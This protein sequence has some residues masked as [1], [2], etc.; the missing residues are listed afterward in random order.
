MFS[1]NQVKRIKALA[2]KK[3]RQESGQFVVEGHKLVTEL[4]Q[5]ELRVLEV[6][7]LPEWIENASLPLA[8]QPEVKV[9]PVKPN[10]MERLTLLNSPSPVL[11]IL[12]IPEPQK[13][14]INPRGLTLVL[15]R[16]NDPGNLGTLIRIADWFGVQQLVCSSDT[17][18][19]YNPKVVQATMGS[20]ARVYLIYTDLVSWLHT[21]KAQFPEI[22]ICGAVMNGE[23][24]YQSELK[25]PAVVVM[26]SESHGI[27]SN[28]LPL[29]SHQLTIPVYGGAESLNV[30][31]AA[32]IMCAEFRRRR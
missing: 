11:A 12:A 18:D 30:A 2:R 19:A 6:W 23:N 16:I 8:H 28:L 7:A 25:A 13:A 32:A 31:A 22:P 27:D 24:L 1:K 26:G 14:D 5:S 3:V 20:L 29:L 4:L 21:S 17:V 15:D 10:E 9:F